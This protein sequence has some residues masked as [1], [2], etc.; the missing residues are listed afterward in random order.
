MMATNDNKRYPPRIR[1]QYRRTTL[2]FSLEIIPGL[3]NQSLAKLG[4]STIRETSLDK[5]RIFAL[6]TDPT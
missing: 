6:P 2:G 3:R 5:V 4:N 1:S